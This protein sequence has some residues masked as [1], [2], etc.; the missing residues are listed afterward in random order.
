[1]S[2]LVGQKLIDVLGITNPADYK[3]HC[4]RWNYID[5]PLDVFITAPDKWIIW[6]NHSPEKNHFNRPFIITLADFYPEPDTWLFCGIYRV[7]NPRKH[8]N[9]DDPSKPHWFYDIEPDETGEEH[10]G[11][12]KISFPYRKRSTRINFSGRTD[13]LI[14]KGVFKHGY[15]GEDFSKPECVNISYGL[16]L[17][18]Y[19]N[20][21]H[22]NWREGL[23]GL[24]G[25]YLITD[26]KENKRYVGSAYGGGG[27]WG[28]WQ[29]YMHTGATG[30][31]KG[32]GELLSSMKKAGRQE[33]AQNYFRF[34]ILESWPLNS[35]SD[36][37]VIRRESHWKEVL[38]SRGP[39]GYNHN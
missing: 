25:V 33:Y 32:L 22:S 3:L 24:D 19:Q 4:A 17:A 26:T 10:V 6:N 12:L 23:S 34:S 20:I 35:K 28:R 8:A 5:Q 15:K 1:M 16:L 21:A 37:E 18:Q 13:D 7:K 11:K 31:N 27:I 30:G 2:S 9:P 39:F 14:V 29:V 36:S 38:L